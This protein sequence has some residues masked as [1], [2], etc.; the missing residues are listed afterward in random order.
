MTIQR[1]YK[2]LT[3]SI[4]LLLLIGCQDSTSSTSTSNQADFEVNGG[5]KTSLSIVA[6][7]EMSELE[8]ILEKY[9]QDH[10]I[11]LSVD[12][13]GSLDIMRMLQSG[14]VPYDAVW[15]ASDIWLTLGDDH[16]IL[17]HT[18]PV[19]ITPVVFG[20]KQSLAE[21]LGFK[22][23]DVYVAD[24]IE[25]I[26]EG[27]LNFAMTSAT[28]SNSGASAY[29][30]FLTALANNPEDGLTTED[31]A[32]PELQEQI[33]SLLSGVNR[34]SGSSNWLVDLFLQ[35]DYD[36]M[37]NYETL[38][39]QTNL[40]LE[41]QNK[42][43]LYIIYP[44]DGLSI[45]NSPLAYVDHEDK[46]KEEQFLS[47]L[48]YLLSDEAQ[49]E[50]EKTGK[51]SQYG[52]VRDENK[53]IYRQEW[54]IDLD[55]V[56]SP[57][58]WPQAEAIRQ[59]LNLFQ[60]QFKK[61]SLTVYVL[62]YSGSMTGEGYHRMIA[63]LEEVLMP[64]RAEA[65]LLQG[66]ERDQIYVLPFNSSV[67]GIESATGNGDELVNLLKTIKDKYRPGGSTYMYEAIDEAVALIANEHG[68]DLNEYFPAIVVLSDGL[69]NGSMSLNNLKDRYQQYAYDI[70]IFSILFADAS[71]TQLEPVAEFS[72]GR[73][74]DG[75][76]DLIEA[77]RNVKGYN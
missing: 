42:E 19:S 53:N 9:A 18:T 71:E 22:E 20:I 26:E 44:V 75:R 13:L 12:Y 63:A 29:L 58:R 74:F 2:W 11:N 21:E 66:T 49:S 70:P 57:I 62:D 43:T 4:L 47:L 17:K 23:R 46:N 31:L 61:P 35:A 32:N 24:L 76:S 38:M 55:R 6:G 73:V 14:D 34:S 77:F 37:V 52:T 51:R 30:G 67:L 59:S 33:T 28:Q 3:V 56:L 40:A 27:K 50:I 69:A 39:I 10:K 45:S 64:D 60:G 1:F 68:D 36:A 15:P 65:N 7:S 54:G 16:R 48:D 5:N 25:A 72:R 8:P 41:E